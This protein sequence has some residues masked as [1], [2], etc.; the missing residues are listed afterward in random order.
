T[1]AHFH[2]VWPPARGFDE[3]KIVAYPCGG[4]DSPSSTR[5][6]FPLTNAPIQLNMEHTAVKGKVLL[7]TGN[8]PTGDDFT[9]V[10]RQQFQEN[11]PDN[12]CIG[13]VNV[14]SSVKAGDNGTILVLTN[15]DPSG[16]LYQV[17]STNEPCQCADVTFTD[18]PLSTSDYTDHCKNSTGVTATL[19]SGAQADASPNGTTTSG[20]KTSSAASSAA[21][22]AAAAKPS[23]GA[24][25]VGAWAVGVLG[26]AGM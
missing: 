12:F 13:G 17:S 20:G 10:L 15:G 1:L 22:T 18:A 11:G 8:S 7:A 5:T 9:T 25:R 23:S 2:L 14:P 16:G 21:S 4:F 24:G 6:P 26:A 19:F 3:D